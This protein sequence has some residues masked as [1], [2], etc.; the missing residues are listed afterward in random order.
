MKLST[1]VLACL[2]RATLKAAIDSGCLSKSEITAIH[3]LR[4]SGGRS[5]EAIAKRK[6]GTAIAKQFIEAKKRTEIIKR[7][8]GDYAR[9]RVEQLNKEAPMTTAADLLEERVSKSCDIQR[10]FRDTIAKYQAAHPGCNK[11]DAIDAVLFGPGTREIVDLE[12]RFDDAVAKLGGGNLPTP[13]PGTMHR[14]HNDFAPRY[15]RAGYDASVD[16]ARPARAHASGGPQSGEEDQPMIED[17]NDVLERLTKTGMRAGKSRA[18]AMS[19]AAMSQEF[20]D[21]HRKERAR[22]Y[23]V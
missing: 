12:R 22:K 16:D 8:I 18:K 4:A 7:A 5:S 9:Q 20:S 17:A 2:S 15:G 19:D 23:G 14:T 21:A 11:A 6:L 3:A 1:A 13:P 10:M